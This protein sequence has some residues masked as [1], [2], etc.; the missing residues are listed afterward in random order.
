M[1]LLSRISEGPEGQ[2]CVA[3]VTVIGAD[4]DVVQAVRGPGQ[5][6][7][8]IQIAVVVIVIE[9]VL[10]TRHDQQCAVTL[11]VDADGQT[12]TLHPAQVEGQIGNRGEVTLSPG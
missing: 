7:S 2:G 10:G 11:A 9:P 12:M 6:D 8:G 1:P 3:M 5:D 4:P